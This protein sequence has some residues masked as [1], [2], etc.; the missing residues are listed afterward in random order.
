MRVTTAWCA[1]RR[2][3]IE[4][5]CEGSAAESSQRPGEAEGSLS[6]EAQARAGAALTTARRTGTTRRFSARSAR[7][8]GVTRV[9]QWLNPL[10][11]GR[12]LQPGGCGPDRSARRPATLAGRGLRS[13]SNAVGGEAARKVCGVLVA[14]LQGEELD[15]NPVDRDVVN[16]G[17]VPK[18]PVPSPRL[19]GGGQVRCRLMASGRGGGSVVVR[20]RESR[21]HGEGTQRAGRAVAGMPGGRR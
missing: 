4:R 8:K 12:R 14:M 19:G 18:P 3:V 10:K 1:T 6:L 5:S 20:G 17:T 21:P 16:V 11:S 9:N 7:R 15:A 13:R 2:Y